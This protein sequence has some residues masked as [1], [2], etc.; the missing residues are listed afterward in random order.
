MEFQ[1][2]ILCRELVSRIGAIPDVLT[3]DKNEARI[4]LAIISALES[5]GTNWK[6][7]EATFLRH[8]KGK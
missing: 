8:L 7:F 6:E 2:W 5:I 4:F 1:N 3:L